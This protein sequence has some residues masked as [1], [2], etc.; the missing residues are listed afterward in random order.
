MVKRRNCQA[1]KFLEDLA[2]SLLRAGTADHLNVGRFQAS[3]FIVRLFHAG[4]VR[5]VL[6]VFFH[7]V[8]L[9]VGNYA[10]HRDGVAHVLGQ[11]SS[12]TAHRPAAAVI[13][14][15][16]ELIVVRGLL[17]APGHRASVALPFVVVVCH[18]P[19]PT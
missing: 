4:V 16:Q 3:V 13:G 19:K 14:F 17:Q 18:R 15:E 1:F 5:H 2:R 6:G 9:G 11:R 10:G 8:H 12:V 7:V